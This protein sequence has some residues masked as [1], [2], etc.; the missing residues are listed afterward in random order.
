MSA[1][2]PSLR[3]CFYAV[4]M[5]AATIYTCCASSPAVG[6]AVI[7]AKYTPP[8]LEVP[9]AQVIRAQYIT[10]RDSVRRK[11][12]GNDTVLRMIQKEPWNSDVLA[13]L[14]PKEKK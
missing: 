6:E 9:D 12:Q 7:R 14:E 2:T 3:C 11:N 5:V 10:L 1:L 8:R 4:S 13:A